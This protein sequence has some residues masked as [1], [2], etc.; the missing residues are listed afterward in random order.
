[1]Y[2]M[3]NKTI[4]IIIYTTDERTFYLFQSQ[5]SKE[6]WMKEAGVLHN[7]LI[8]AANFLLHLWNKQPRNYASWLPFTFGQKEFGLA[9]FFAQLFFF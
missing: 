7:F 9:Y 4:I 2:W 8:T 5:A 3:S 1:M 6:R